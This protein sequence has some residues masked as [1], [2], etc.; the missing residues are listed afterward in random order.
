MVVQ[1][2]RAAA[3]KASGIRQRGHFAE[4]SGHAGL[5]RSQPRRLQDLCRFLDSQMLDPSRELRSHGRGMA[6]AASRY[7]APSTS[8]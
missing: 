4:S 2:T 1:T 3:W 8:F 7:L 6:R 5:G